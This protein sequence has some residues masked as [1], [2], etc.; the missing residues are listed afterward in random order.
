MKAV[1]LT[2]KHHKETAETKAHTDIMLNG[3]YIGY[4]IGKTKTVFFEYRNELFAG[5][6]NTI[7]DLKNEVLNTIK[8]F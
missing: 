7:K 2:Y 8:N 4:Y 6:F 1:I 5:E 3:T